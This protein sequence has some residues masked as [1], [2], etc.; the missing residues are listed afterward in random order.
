MND[1]MFFSISLFIMIV[2]IATSIYI[3]CKIMGCETEEPDRYTEVAGVQ[4]SNI[5]ILISVQ[6]LVGVGLIFTIGLYVIWR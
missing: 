4:F 1:I 6:M 3:I 5:R 2:M